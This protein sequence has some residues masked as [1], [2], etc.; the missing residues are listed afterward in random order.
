MEQTG[1]PAV[2]EAAVPRGEALVGDPIHVRHRPSG[3]AGAGEAQCREAGTDDPARIHPRRIG[4][5]LMIRVLLVDLVVLA[6]Q[7]GIVLAGEL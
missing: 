6:H 4:C 7:S 3:H 2:V 1:K 5:E